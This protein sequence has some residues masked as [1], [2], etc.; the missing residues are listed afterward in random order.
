[1]AEET[2]TDKWKLQSFEL[3]KKS[4]LEVKQR[5]MSKAPL[6]IFVFQKTVPREHKVQREGEKLGERN[7]KQ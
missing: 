4:Q 2:D 5:I 1:M 6:A 3:K 7:L